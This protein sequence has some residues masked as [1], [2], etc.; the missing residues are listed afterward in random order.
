MIQ[1]RKARYSKT[2]YEVRKGGRI[3]LKGRDETIDWVA[4][5]EL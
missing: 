2:L 4:R 1:G 5:Q 3:V